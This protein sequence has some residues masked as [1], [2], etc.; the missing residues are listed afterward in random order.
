MKK[1]SNVFIRLQK[2]ALECKCIQEHAKVCRGKVNY[3]DLFKCM[4]KYAK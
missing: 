1:R 4:H 2:Y 3:E